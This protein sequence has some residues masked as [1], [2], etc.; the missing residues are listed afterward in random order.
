MFHIFQNRDFPHIVLDWH[1]SIIWIFDATVH[2]SFFQ[3]FNFHYCYIK[4]QLIFFILTVSCNLELQQELIGSK[5]FFGDSL[6]F[7]I[8]KINLSVNR[9]ICT[10]S[11][12]SICLR[13]I[14]LILMYWLGL[15]IWYWLEVVR[16]DIFALS[17]LLVRSI[18]S[19]TD[20]YNVSCKFSENALFHIKKFTSI[21][22]LVRVCITDVEYCHLVFVNLLILPYFF[23]FT[24]LKWWIVILDFLTLKSLAYPR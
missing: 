20:K 10:Y 9:Q 12:V 22:S 13:Y 8:Y 17:S 4:I 7:S 18:Q 6:I 15:S 2:G 19:F 14:F 11:Y 24:L 5:T 23:F 16:T 1:L 3:F 21:L